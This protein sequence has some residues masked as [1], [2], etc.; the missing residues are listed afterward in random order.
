[1]QGAR[2]I[3]DFLFFYSYFYFSFF[4]PFILASLHFSDSSVIVSIEAIYLC[5][6]YF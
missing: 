4:Y 5:Y 6:T 3:F 2:K 1:M